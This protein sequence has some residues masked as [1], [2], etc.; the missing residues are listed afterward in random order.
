[1]QREG[2][3]SACVF[4]TPLLLEPRVGGQ[5][6]VAHEGGLLDVSTQQLLQ[7]LAASLG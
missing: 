6:K 2:F 7:A 1:M 3:N 5:L 4:G